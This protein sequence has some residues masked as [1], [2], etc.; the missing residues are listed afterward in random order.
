MASELIVR[1]AACTS[2]LILAG[3]PA[4]SELLLL[5]AVL[6]A[7]MLFGLACVVLDVSSAVQSAFGWTP[8]PGHASVEPAHVAT[9]DREQELIER[10]HN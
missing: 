2:V 8:P 9:R 5:N 1:T 3:K 4:S 6:L 10:L 7:V